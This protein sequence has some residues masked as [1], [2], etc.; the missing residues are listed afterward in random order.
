[1]GE[2]AKAFARDLDPSGMRE[3]SMSEVLKDIVGTVQKI[4][5][6]E[7][8]LA[9]AEVRVEAA[10]AWKPVRLLLIGA[11]VGLLAAGATPERFFRLEIGKENNIMKYLFAW[12]L[13]VPGVLIVIWF[14][15]SHH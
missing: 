1:M 13:G 8:R 10:R 15:M 2:S 3:R 5:R 14:L 7:A 9:K 6:G 4:V 12:G 11:I